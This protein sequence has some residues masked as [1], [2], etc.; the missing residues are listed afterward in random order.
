MNTTPHTC[1]IHKSN[2][3][4]IHTEFLFMIKIGGPSNSAPVV[5]VPNRD[6][7]IPKPGSPI[8]PKPKQLG[9]SCGS[10][11]CPPTYTAGECEEGLD[12]VHNPMIADAPGKCIN[13][14][15]NSTLIQN[16]QINYVPFNYSCNLA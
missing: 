15:K 2:E 5:K 10:C 7:F 9:E 13:R 4:N 14:G 8:K 1:R 11:N 16:G 3:L 12:C 6:I